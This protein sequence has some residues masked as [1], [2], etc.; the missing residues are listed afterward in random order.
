MKL[1][2]PMYNV[3]PYFSFKN[4]GK[5]C[6]LNMAKYGNSITHHLYIVLCVRHSQSSLLLSPF[7]LHLTLF[8]L[9]QS[10]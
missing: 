1:A 9:S 8:H 3:H 7:I 2:L 6:T 5:K 4:L 10:P